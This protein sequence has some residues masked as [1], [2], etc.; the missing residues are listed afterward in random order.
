[1]V[2]VLPFS[3]LFAAIVAAQQPGCYSLSGIFLPLAG[4]VPPQP[5]ELSMLV[6][7]TPTPEEFKNYD[8]WQSSTECHLPPR[9]VPLYDEKARA[10]APGRLYQAGAIGLGGRPAV[11]GAA[12]HALGHLPD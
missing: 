8:V 11:K 4:C 5:P 10:N 9:L 2:P 7:P 3:V 6:V 12:L 1:M